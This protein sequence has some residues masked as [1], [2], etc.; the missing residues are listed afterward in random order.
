MRILIIRHGDPDYDND[1]LTEKGKREAKLLSKK[2]QGEQIDF[3]YTSPLGRAKETCMTYARAVNKET[4]VVEKDWL[5]EF[6]YPTTFPSGRQSDIPWDMLPEEWAN[7]ETFYSCKGWFNHPCY[8]GSGLEEKY[9]GVVRNFDELIA[10]H[11]YVRDG[12]TYRVEKRNRN[13]IALFCH[14]GLE[15]VLLSRLCNISPVVL[16]HNFVALPTSVTTLYTEERRDGKAIFRCAG[17]GDVGHLY[18]GE[19]IPS[20]SARFCET[21]DCKEERRD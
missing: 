11:G 9:L 4:T 20:F 13:T 1:C 16:W 17:F 18:A 2:L 14:F 15:S 7:D 8:Q 5:R 10:K 12:N 6:S 21:V 3:L 19:E